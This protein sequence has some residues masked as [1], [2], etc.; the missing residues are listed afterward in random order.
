MA[1][2]GFEP[3][4]HDKVKSFFK[5]CA[6][7]LIFPVTTLKFQQLKV[8]FIFPKRPGLRSMRQRIWALTDHIYQIIGH[9]HKKEQHE[10]VQEQ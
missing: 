6:L 5:K 7:F 8:M 9:R 1:E 3:R 4:V 10:C 2:L